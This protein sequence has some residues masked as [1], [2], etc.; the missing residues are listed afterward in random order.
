MLTLLQFLLIN[1]AVVLIY[2]F[3]KVVA[4]YALPLPRVP[5]ILLHHLELLAGSPG[6][7]VSMRLFNHKRRK[8]GYQSSFLIVL[9]I[10]LVMGAA[11]AWYVRWSLPLVAF[12][13]ADVYMM[14]ATNGAIGRSAAKGSSRRAS[15]DDC[16]K[17]RQNA[18]SDAKSARKQVRRS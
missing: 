3:D 9:S 11:W 6:A 1:A 12:L 10:Q 13:A 17:P 16:T 4:V 2:C 18:A 15:D 14:A 5:E 7:F 8:R